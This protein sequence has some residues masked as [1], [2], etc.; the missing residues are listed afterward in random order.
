VTKKISKLDS[1]N[2]LGN[3]SP[4]PSQIKTQQQKA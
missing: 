1:K 2:L 3:S 4:S